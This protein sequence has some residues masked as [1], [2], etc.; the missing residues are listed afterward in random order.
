[1]PLKQKVILG[2]IGLAVVAMLFA[3]S[4]EPSVGGADNCPGRGST[5]NRRRRGPARPTAR[6]T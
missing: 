6:R 2:V 4:R 1:M 5:P 3:F